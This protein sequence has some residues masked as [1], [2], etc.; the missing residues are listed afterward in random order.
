MYNVVYDDNNEVNNFE[1][2]EYEKYRHFSRANVYRKNF[3]LNCGNS[4]YSAVLI[5]SPQTRK[6]NL[7]AE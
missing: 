6:K 5:T 7:T 3:K 4:F 2:T 1:G